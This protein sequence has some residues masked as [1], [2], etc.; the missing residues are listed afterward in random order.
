MTNSPQRGKLV[1]IAGPSGVG[2]GTVVRRAVE[3]RP[4]LW[5]SVSATTRSPRPDEVDGMDYVFMSPDRFEEL[6]ANG[7]FLESADFTGNSYG[8]PRA[9]VERRLAEGTDVLLEID[10]QGV[11][12]VKSV[13]PQAR[14]AFI[15]P[16]SWQ[17]LEERLTSRGTE[18]AATVAARLFAA[19]AEL[20]AADEFDHRI[21]NADVNEAARQLIAWIG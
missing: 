4:D 16:P 19:R 8:T 13:M 6:K 5:L 9:P 20:A 3:L 17:A 7:G 21:T 15:L 14:S 11:R 2:K 10:V 12:L 18:D 1:V